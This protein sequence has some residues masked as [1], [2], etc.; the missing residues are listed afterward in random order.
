MNTGAIILVENVIKKKVR[1]NSSKLI[2]IK[3]VTAVGGLLGLFIA[4]NAKNIVEAIWYIAQYYAAMI[5]VPFIGGLFIKNKS[6][7][8]FWGSTAAGFISYTALRLLFSEIEH[9]AYLI[10]ISMSFIVFTLIKLLVDKN[11]IDNKQF[12]IKLE[13]STENIIKQ[14]NIPITKLGYAILPIQFHCLQYLLRLL[15]MK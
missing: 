14:M 13:N 9:T 3:I 5:V 2:I 10:S 7:Y 1:N 12:L 6:P 8:I 4:L 11:I 15:Q